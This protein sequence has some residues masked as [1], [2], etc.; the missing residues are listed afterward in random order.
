MAT[1]RIRGNL[2]TQA[3]LSGNLYRSGGGGSTVT[4]DPVYNSGIKIADYSV[5]DEPGEIYI[6]DTSGIII[7]TLL[8]EQNAVTVGTTYTFLNDR[9]LSDYDFIEL[10][11]ATKENV[12][13]NLGYDRWVMSTHELL[14]IPR[15][16]YGAY[17]N[18]WFY[19]DIT[20]TSFTQINTSGDQWPY[21]YKIIG[22]KIK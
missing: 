16:N 11:V 17:G 4:I 6:P 15:I 22:I 10:L 3:R 14:N 12:S 9:K 7:D 18:R 13:G 20:E 21:V 19:A 1:D 2:S 5:D 8:D